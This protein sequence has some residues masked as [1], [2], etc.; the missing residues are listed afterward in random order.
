MGGRNRRSHLLRP[1][2]TSLLGHI[3]PRVRRRL[4]RSDGTLA[5]LFVQGGPGKARSGGIRIREFCAAGRSVEDRSGSGNYS[6]DRRERGT[7]VCEE[8][9]RGRG[10]ELRERG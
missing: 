7:K 5:G 2:G 9:R 6:V 10:T 1:V 3:H 4:P 8:G